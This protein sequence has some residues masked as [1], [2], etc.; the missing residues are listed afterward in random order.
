MASSNLEISQNLSLTLQ[1][2]SDKDCIYSEIDESTKNYFR[3]DS[4]TSLQEACSK[5]E[6]KILIS[7]D[8]L[9]LKTA[10]FDK[11]QQI[12]D[13]SSLTALTIIIDYFSSMYNNAISQ[14]VKNGLQSLCIKAKCIETPNILI[15]HLHFYSSL[16]IFKIECKKYRELFFGKE[17]DKDSDYSCIKADIDAGCA[18]IIKFN[19]ET[20]IFLNTTLK[21][22]EL[23]KEDLV[24]I[25]TSQVEYLKESQIILAVSIA[26]NYEFY[27]KL[28][29][30]HCELHNDTV[31]KM[32]QNIARDWN[33]KTVA[34]N[35]AV[36]K[37]EKMLPYLSNFDINQRYTYIDNNFQRLLDIAVVNN[38]LEMTVLLY[39]KGADIVRAC[40]NNAIPNKP[41][42]Y[43][44]AFRDLLNVPFF[45]AIRNRNEHLKNFF[46]SRE[47]S[48]YDG[49][50]WIIFSN[51]RGEFNNIFES[52]DIDFLKPISK[53]LF[54]GFS[55]FQLMIYYQRTGFFFEVFKKYALDPLLC[56]DS[57]FPERES[58]QFG[59][60][61]VFSV[62]VHTG[63]LNELE[64][65]SKK[66]NIEKLSLKNNKNYNAIQLL[67][68]GASEKSC[69][70]DD[71]LYGVN[72]TETLE[73]HKKCM[74]LILKFIT[75]KGLNLILYDNNSKREVPLLHF[76][77]LYD[78]F[79]VVEEH[80]Q[81]Y[82]DD[83]K[84]KITIPVKN[85]EQEVD[86]LQLA[87][88]LN[89]QDEK[90]FD[91]LFQHK[92]YLEKSINEPLDSLKNVN[93]FQ[94]SILDGNL[95]F[96]IKCLEWKNCPV[97]VPF[98]F[99]HH[100]YPKWLPIHVIVLKMMEGTL[101]TDYSLLLKRDDVDV[102]TPMP[103]QGVPHFLAGHY[104]SSAI[105]YNGNPVKNSLS[106]S[107]IIS[108]MLTDF[109]PL[110]DKLPS[111]TKRN[112]LDQALLFAIAY[113]DVR[114]SYVHD[115]E[116]QNLV[117]HGA[118]P[119]QSFGSN[120]DLII[121]LA[122]ERGLLHLFPQHL[123]NRL[124]AVTQQILLVSG[125]VRESELSPFS[126]DFL[127]INEDYYSVISL[128]RNE[129]SGNSEHVFITIEQIVAGRSK[130]FFIDFV[131]N[132]E[133]KGLGMVRCILETGKI[134]D[135]LLYS[136]KL[137]MMKIGSIEDLKCSSWMVP[138]E[139]ANK[140]LVLVEEEKSKN[141]YYALPGNRS[142]FSWFGSQ[143]GHNC[144]TWARE[145]LLST[146]SP[147]IKQALK[148]TL[149]EWLAAVPSLKDSS[150][151]K[152]K[153]LLLSVTAAAFGAVCTGLNFYISYG[154]DVVSLKP[155]L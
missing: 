27:S 150:W 77:I 68:D 70:T 89:C 50:A 144:Y 93:L 38:H 10:F 54:S 37:F 137:S 90:V 6:D 133:K 20:E 26:D 138:N 39:N 143:K 135:P 129:K 145:K 126:K 82:E 15:E 115:K 22:Y 4:L 113:Y 94:Q 36:T 19:K 41:T 140:L 91:K 112:I 8:E 80:L 96:F 72:K 69:N 114:A 107:P 58:I 47:E 74:V 67:L 44:N 106:S 116:I 5:K 148:L 35:N 109:F 125:N 60:W 62:V 98:P 56:F 46:I 16:L 99:L 119:Y 105:F 155:E 76:C 79:S 14:L 78:I 33:V 92:D 45:I 30:F 102:T 117:E 122:R 55:L 17:T 151:Y 42:A 147:I 9:L 1:K 53:G 75:I 84:L 86:A 136:C 25:S 103:D 7:G 34:S 71:S 134:T 104:L 85:T 131:K 52:T 127:R 141:I 121:D 149:G 13:I 57:V 81:L 87:V 132:P 3:V 48:L 146:K 24:V 11:N 108:I 95:L 101:N 130:M 73:N 31:F 29:K 139:V 128:V 120:G 88:I 23:K 59:G 110:L 2:V 18:E 118:N 124:R 142:I 63:M 28:E 154:K 61:S 21:T 123:E 49:L 12:K 64:W 40:E 65:I 153:C 66:I 97:N 111:K 83:V 32:L 152:N 51:E 43:F 100:Q